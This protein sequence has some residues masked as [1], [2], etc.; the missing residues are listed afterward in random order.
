MTMEHISQ[1]LQVMRDALYKARDNEVS[2]ASECGSQYIT[3]HN[4]ADAYRELDKSV[5][6][7]ARAWDKMIAKLDKW[8]EEANKIEASCDNFYG[9]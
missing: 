6:R 5:N 7:L 3:D 9:D 2:M 8:T 1:Q 4:D